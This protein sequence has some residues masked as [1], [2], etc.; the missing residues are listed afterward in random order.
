MT[1]HQG[2]AGNGARILA[3]GA[4][5]V[6]LEPHVHRDVE[7]REREELPY[8][9]RSSLNSFT[10]IRTTSRRQGFRDTLTGSGKLD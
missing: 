4:L 7:E 3:A 10:N 8:G 5:A 6:L 9:G 1:K 2:R